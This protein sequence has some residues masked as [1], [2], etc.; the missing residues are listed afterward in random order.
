MPLQNRVTPF[1]EIVSVAGRGMLMGNRGILH[2]DNQ[3]LTKRWN[4]RNW[5]YCLLDFKGRKRS[6]MQP[7][8]YT[9]L[10]FL[11]EATALTAGHRPCGEC[12]RPR[13]REFKAV[14]AETQQRG[15]GP[16]DMDQQLNRDRLTSGRR[17]RSQRQFSTFFKNLPDF[18]MV[19]FNGSAHL[20]SSN[21]LL[22][23]SSAGY[24]SAI[25]IGGHTVVDVLTPAVTVEVF[26]LGFTPSLHP[27][28]R[29]L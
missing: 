2:N 22:E 25:E 3:E 17:N 13:Y 26:R 21:R 24:K 6:L 5:V 9:E 12:Q 15:M 27:S 10:F 19:S 16:A 29:R 20:K 18:T 28:A 14:M 7:H 1:G 23:W 11:D 8:A 4:H